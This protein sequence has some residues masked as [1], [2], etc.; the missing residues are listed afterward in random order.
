MERTLNETDVDK[1]LQYRVDYNNGPF[2]SISFMS[3]I[4]ST[5]ESLHSEFVE[6]M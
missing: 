2:H 3:T 5:S 6:E 4:P 1:N